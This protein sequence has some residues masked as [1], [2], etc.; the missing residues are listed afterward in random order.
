MKYFR[1]DSIFLS[2]HSPV[3]KDMFSIPRP[4]ALETFDGAPLVRLSDS[5]NDVEK[6]LNALSNPESFAYSRYNPR[7]P[8]LVTG[9][10]LLAKKYQMD[11]IRTL[12]LRN[13]EHDWPY[14]LAG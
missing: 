10:L 4:P 6:L 13:I 9:I 5:A 7:T 14:N 8:S 1:V 3:F 11:S 12:I 2:R